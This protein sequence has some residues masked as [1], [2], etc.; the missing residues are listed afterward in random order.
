MRRRLLAASPSCPERGDDAPDLHRRDPTGAGAAPAGGGARGDE[1]RG[2]GWLP[3]AAGR[4]VPG[5][6]RGAAGRAAGVADRLHRIGGDRGG[7]GGTCGAFRR[8]PL[9]AAGTR[10][11]RGRD[12]GRELAR[13]QAGGVAGGGAG[14]RRARRVRSVAAHRGADDGAARGDRDQGHRAGAGREPRR[15]CL[16][17]PAGSADGP[18]RGAV[19]GGRRRDLVG[20]AQPAGRGA[21]PRGS[22]RGGHHPAGQHRVAA[23][24][25]R[26][27]RGADAGAARLR[28]PARGCARRPVRGARQD[29]WSRAGRRRHSPAPETPLPRR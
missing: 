11:G 3:G 2:A 1:G 23:E 5:R 27:G 21:A 19:A 20:Q 25:P 4:H 15:P 24:H 17:G 10:P 6:E 13:H 22:G 7:S 18:H 8:R 9:P 28:D 29:R 16:G 12:R 14:G 26:V